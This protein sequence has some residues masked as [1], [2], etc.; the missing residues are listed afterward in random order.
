MSDP[1]SKLKEIQNNYTDVLND[2]LN[3]E[4]SP[5]QI[6][7][8]TVALSKFS[9]DVLKEGWSEFIYKV[10][11][12]LMPSIEDCTKIMDTIRMNHSM[13]Q[14]SALKKDIPKPPDEESVNFTKWMQSIIYGIRMKTAGEW[15]ELER[16]NYMLG[17]A[18]EVELP[19]RD[20]HAME[21]ELA[22]Y[23]RK[24]PNVKKSPI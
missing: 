19:S 21:V 4:M 11:P 5:L 9:D 20:L 6:K 10:R 14:H 8:W 12:G 15:T 16:L 1:Q 23:K 7:Q 18:K 22:T 2:F 17:K 24:N 3:I 13:D